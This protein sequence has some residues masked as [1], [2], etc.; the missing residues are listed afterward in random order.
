LRNIFSIFNLI[1]QFAVIFLD[2][3]AFSIALSF[4]QKGDRSSFSITTE[5]RSHSTILDS[6]KAIAFS[7][8]TEKRSPSTILDSRKAIAPHSTKK[9]IALH[10]L[11]TSDRTP[12][13]ITKE[14]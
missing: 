10:K 1:K 12:F 4:E 5:K 3:V 8:T 7:I 13:S 11:Q 9:A 14:K 6:R 2:V